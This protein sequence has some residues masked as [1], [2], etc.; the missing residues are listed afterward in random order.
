METTNPIAGQINLLPLQTGVSPQGM[1]TGDNDSSPCGP[2]TAILQKIVEGNGCRG[3]L[4]QTEDAP[5]LPFKDLPLSQIQAALLKDAQT[6]DSD[7]EKNRVIAALQQIHQREREG[8]DRQRF[9]EQFFSLLGMV[10]GRSIQAPNNHL[11]WTDDPQRMSMEQAILTSLVRL[12]QPQKTT[13]NEKKE[14]EPAE[15]NLIPD[16]GAEEDESTEAMAEEIVALL[17]LLDGIA[18]RQDLSMPEPGK[19][20]DSGV[21]DPG[22]DSIA[23][24]GSTEKKAPNRFPTPTETEAAGDLSRGGKTDPDAEGLVQS[25]DNG[26]SSTVSPE[27]VPPGI[28]DAP[29]LSSFEA[30]NQAATIARGSEET[31][32]S[33]QKEAIGPEIRSDGPTVTDPA[34]GESKKPA[35]N[36]AGATKIDTYGDVQR[37][38]SAAGELPSDKPSSGAATRP[39]AV[40]AIDG[41]ATN[42]KQYTEAA[43]SRF[44]TDRVENRQAA[45]NVEHAVSQDQQ[46]LMGKTTDKTEPLSNK[47]E[48]DIARVDGFSKPRPFDG[49]EEDSGSRQLNQNMGGQGIMETVSGEKPEASSFG[50]IVADRI[51]RTVEHIAQTNRTD[52]ALRLKIDGNESVF[53][54]MKERAGVITIGIQCR[55]KALV[56]ALESQKEV[57]VRNLETK[58]LNTSISIAGAGEDEPD[59]HRQWRRERQEQRRDNWSGRQANSRSYFET[60]I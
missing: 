9:I 1:Q 44:H 17:A 38:A 34:P 46:G 48:P 41:E 7:P 27:T 18:G 28:Q 5:A 30:S 13:T 26:Q 39:D 51:A 53:L 19:A 21:G 31:E 35:G 20:K 24:K 32:D 4:S 59:G 25:A 36:A 15:E 57:M 47:I 6:H 11:S 10:D 52:L 29:L 12:I 55:D 3:G 43:Y 8:T 54:E 58:N 33:R 40:G 2:F 60:L 23:K 50:N 45:P 49:R 56:K 22:N 16:D 14:M 42:A 37:P